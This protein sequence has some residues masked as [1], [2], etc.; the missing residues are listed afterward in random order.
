MRA[1]LS[2]LLVALLVG[3]PALARGHYSAAHTKKLIRLRQYPKHGKSVTSL[4][5]TPHG[6]H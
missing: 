1:S 2:L 6:Q 3:T 4:N 5:H